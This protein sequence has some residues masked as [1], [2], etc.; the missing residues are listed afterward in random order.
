MAHLNC[1]RIYSY[2]SAR[3]GSPC[4]KGPIFWAPSIFNGLTAGRPTRKKKKKSAWISFTFFSTNWLQEKTLWQENS[5]LEMH[6]GKKERCSTHQRCSYCFSNSLKLTLHGDCASLPCEKTSC[7]LN[8]WL[9][10][11]SLEN[12]WRSPEGLNASHR[13]ADF[14]THSACHC[15]CKT[16]V[17][18]PGL[19]K[20]AVNS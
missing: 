9:G 13:T 7:T 4:H 12:V 8:V 17:Q 14:Q 15:L 6:E 10:V 11:S 5:V 19:H 3:R 2:W 18:P 20:L 16:R 1:T